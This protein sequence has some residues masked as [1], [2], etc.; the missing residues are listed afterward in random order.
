MIL[1]DGLSLALIWVGS[2]STL[3]VGSPDLPVVYA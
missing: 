1:F 3:P 2:A